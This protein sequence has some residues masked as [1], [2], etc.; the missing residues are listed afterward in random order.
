MTTRE[1]L[2]KKRSETKLLN[3]WFL[4]D[5]DSLINA[6]LSEFPTVLFSRNEKELE[7]EFNLAIEQSD[8][9]MAAA[10]AI[11]AVNAILSVG[12]NFRIFSIWLERVELLLSVD[13]LSHVVVAA[14]ELNKFTIHLLWNAPIK[15]L[16]SDI[17]RVALIVKKSES[18]SLD[19]IFSTVSAYAYIMAGNFYA[20]EQ[21]LLDARYLLKNSEKKT[22]AA[23]HLSSCSTLFESVK[24]EYTGRAAEELIVFLN[25][26]TTSILPSHVPMMAQCHLLLWLIHCEKYKEAN[27]LAEKLKSAFIPEH[28][29][30]LSSYVQFSLGVSALAQFKAS[31]A[32]VHANLASEYARLCEAISGQ[33]LAALLR[34]QALVDLNE[35]IEALDQLQSWMPK[36]LEK[37]FQ[38]LAV[39]GC[40]ELAQL[41]L[42]ESRFNE[43]KLRFEQAE[44]LLPK[45]ESLPDYHRKKSFSFGLRNRLFESIQMK[46]NF[47]G[48]NQSS[49]VSITTLGTF[50]LSVSGY[51]IYDRYWKGNKL[52]LLL[53]ALI[54]EGGHKI[55]IERLCDL[56]WPDADGQQ[57]RQNLKVAIFRLRRMVESNSKKCD[58]WL[59]QKQGNI[60]L[61]KDC[62]DVDVFKFDM[63]SCSSSI[64]DQ[65]AALE[66]YKGDFLSGDDSENWI[67]AHRERIR[68][69]Y[70]QLVHALSS[71]KMDKKY[72]EL[73]EK[74]LLRMVDAE[75][76]DEFSFDV[77]VDFYNLHGKHPQAERI[78]KWRNSLRAVHIR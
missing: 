40:L 42:N 50:T 7:A 8:N 2:V 70:V 71:T 77:L 36:W 35:G 56:L 29:Y 37:G 4:Q 32:L 66:I 10:A 13:D 73:V 65:I 38:M 69:R 48:M 59:V 78:N 30:Y 39:A 63:L 12:T 51:P 55:S 60:S 28:N 58:T 54:V 15:A 44:R 11:A 22:L 75:S 5:I 49:L 14:L 18:D 31:E 62:C 34:L 45:G 64:E 67:M 24:S 21:R 3:F 52:K 20:A 23:F 25:D 43:A 33:Y 19:V 6:D 46:N 9:I 27:I 16:I 53:K 26:T 68:K 76:A 57:A 74:H 1:G 61:K 17:S 41:H 47:E 72:F